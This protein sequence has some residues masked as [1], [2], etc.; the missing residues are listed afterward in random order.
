METTENRYE[1][2]EQELI[3]DKASRELLLSI[4]YWSKVL[5]AISFLV[6]GV[7]LFIILNRSLWHISGVSHEADALLKLAFDIIV[8]LLGLLLLLF[9]INVNK[10]LKTNHQPFLINALANLNSVFKIVGVVVVIIVLARIIRP[11]I[12]EDIVYYMF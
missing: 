9:S 11:F 10:A 6:F 1:L 8:F 5:S 7:K 2:P 12:F 4:S 3:L